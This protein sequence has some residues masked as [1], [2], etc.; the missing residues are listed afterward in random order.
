MTDPLDNLMYAFSGNNW[1]RCGDKHYCATDVGMVRMGPATVAALK[2][3]SDESRRS[4]L[5][6]IG[7]KALALWAKD[8]DAF[9]AFSKAG[10]P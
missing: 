7:D 9:A 4:I 3:G 5:D 10:T 2:A 6:E 1:M 8:D